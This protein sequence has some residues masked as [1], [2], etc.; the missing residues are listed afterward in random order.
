M[1]GWSWTG[2]GCLW[3]ITW[4]IRPDWNRG[5]GPF[6]AQDYKRYVRLKAAT[7]PRCCTGSG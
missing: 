2:T 1:T 4:L 7:A 3:P 6:Q 5:Q